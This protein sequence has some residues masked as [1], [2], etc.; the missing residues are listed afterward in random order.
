M[1]HVSL[2]TQPHFITLFI[3]ALTTAL[4]C[5]VGWRKNYRVFQKKYI[6]T[7][8]HTNKYLNLDAF[9]HI[10]SQ[11]KLKLNPFKRTTTWYLDSSKNTP[12]T[13]NSW[14]WCCNIKKNRTSIYHHM[15]IF[16]YH[17]KIWNSNENFMFFFSSRKLSFFVKKPFC[18]ILKL[19]MIFCE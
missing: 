11:T 1:Y 19:Q 13:H 9:S 12:L 6:K 4:R 16:F 2:L 8:R 14:V 17:P 3:F 5:Y 10:S 7:C 18:F 15:Q